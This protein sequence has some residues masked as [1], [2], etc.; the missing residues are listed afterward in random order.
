METDNSQQQMSLDFR[1]K[2]A[3]YTHDYDEVRILVSMGADPNTKNG[4]GSPLI[5]WCAEKGRLDLIDYVWDNGAD[6]EAVNKSGATALHRVSFLGKVDIIEGLICRGAN[7]NQKNMY[8]ATPL[9]IAA[10]H[11]QKEAVKA[12]L[13]LGADPSIRHYNGL[14]ACEKAKENGFD[15]IVCLFEAG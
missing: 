10:N 12:F 1:L 6:I 7:V 15:H 3:M 14:T 2:H 9:F 5:F 4:W 8:D 13:K 11:G